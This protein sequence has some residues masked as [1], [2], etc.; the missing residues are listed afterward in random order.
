M[1]GNRIEIAESVTLLAVAGVAGAGRL[2]IA[3]GSILRTRRVDDRAD[4]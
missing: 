1:Q 4:G 2:P 3:W